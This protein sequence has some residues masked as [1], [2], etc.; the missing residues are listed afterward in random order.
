MPDITSVP[1]YQ[2][3][4]EDD[5]VGEKVSITYNKNL[6]QLTSSLT[7]PVI[8]CVYSDPI[9]G[10]ECDTVQ[11]CEVIIQSRGTAT[12]TESVRKRCTEF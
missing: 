5:I 1:D 4:C 12:T 7:F 6:R 9:L 11:P 8:K 3:L 10:V 2:V